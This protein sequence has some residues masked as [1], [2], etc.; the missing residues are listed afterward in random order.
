LWLTL[1]APNHP[2]RG[3]QGEVGRVRN[4]ANP[5]R[6]CAGFGRARRA[7]KHQSES[8]KKGPALEDEPENAVGAGDQTGD[9]PNRRQSWQTDPQPQGAGELHVARSHEAGGVEQQ[10][11]TK[12]CSC[13]EKCST[14]IASKRPRS[15]RQ[16]CEC[17]GGPC[18][19]KP[20]RNAAHPEV[21][22]DNKNQPQ[23]KSDVQTQ[24]VLGSLPAIAANMF[25]SARPIP[26]VLLNAATRTI[27]IN[28]AIIPYSIAVAPSSS[29]RKRAIDPSMISLSRS[30]NK[31]LQ[32]NVIQR[33]SVYQQGSS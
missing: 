14:P 28:P 33:N 27:A 1:S 19:H 25:V 24:R 32:V 5:A 29:R 26:V 3:G 30:V 4:G 20:V 8:R 15:Q 21:M 7:G 23:E 13:A 31:D 16:G 9:D 17:K 18:E 12:P 11:N 6:G 10:E 22:N 2:R